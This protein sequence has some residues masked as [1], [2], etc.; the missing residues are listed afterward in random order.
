MS[1]GIQI[2]NFGDA[3]VKAY[4]VLVKNDPLRL[5]GATA[6][7]TTFALPPILLLLIQLLSLVFNR[8]AVSIQLFRELGNI[9]GEGSVDQVVEILKGFR[10]LASNMPLAIAGVF[11]MLFVAT[12][13]FKVIQSSLNQVWRI[14]KSGNKK[15]KMAMLTRLKSTLVIVFTGLLF[16][17]SIALESLKVVF[18][19]YLDNIFPV[20]GFYLNGTIA[21]LV[22]IIIVW[23][24]FSVLFRYLP[25]GEPE[26]RVALSG[27]LLTSFL[28]NAGVV[29]LKWLLLHSNIGAVYGAS[30]SIVFLLLF[31][32]YSSLIFY[33]GAA[34]TKV[35][36]EHLGKPIQPV[37]NAESYL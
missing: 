2:K 13:L 4:K 10:G 9:V 5:A 29:V 12:T 24:W 27:G 32:F 28:Y 36:G 21:L 11:F 18:G 22:S 23:T 20:A 1:I 34:F 15:F 26:W 31:L 16:M 19:N 35:W 3:L 7:F 17:A 8:G 14:Q 37:R 33:F 6:F 25:D 30:A